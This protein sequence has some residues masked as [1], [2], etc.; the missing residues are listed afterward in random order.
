MTESDRNTSLSSNEMPL[1]FFSDSFSTLRC[2]FM[3]Q[4]KSTP[5]EAFMLRKI[6]TLS[7]F[8]II[9]FLYNKLF[10]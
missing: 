7:A 1:F 2:P 4:N 3:F 10:Y 9:L 6:F 8:A 5:Y